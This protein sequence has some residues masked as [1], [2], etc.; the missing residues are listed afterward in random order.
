MAKKPLKP[1]FSV[2]VTPKTY[3][4][5]MKQVRTE[6]DL[7]NFRAELREAVQASQPDYAGPAKAKKPKPASPRGEQ[8]ARAQEQKLIAT[9]AQEAGTGRGSGKRFCDF[10]HRYGVHV[11]P[12]W[13]VSTWPEVWKTKALHPKLRAYKSRN[14]KN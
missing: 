10:L 12:D 6:I 7:D 3:R 14:L 4:Q 8:L 2:P 13:K 5:T 11:P 9:A 1:L